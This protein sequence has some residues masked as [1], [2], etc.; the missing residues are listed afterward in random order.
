MIYRGSGIEL[1]CVPNGDGKLDIATIK[2]QM[3]G[4]QEAPQT[5]QR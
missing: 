1:R 4:K 5:Q 3:P 2:S